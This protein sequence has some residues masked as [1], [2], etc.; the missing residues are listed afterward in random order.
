MREKREAAIFGHRP[1]LEDGRPPM[2]W[3]ADMR[4]RTRAQ[5]QWAVKLIKNNREMIIRDKVANPFNNASGYQ[6][7]NNINK[8]KTCNSNV[9][10]I[11]YGKSG[12]DACNVFKNKYENVHNRATRD[13]ELGGIVPGTHTRI[14]RECKSR[15][16]SPDHLN[17]VTVKHII[18]TI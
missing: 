10:E 7:W 3:L 11:I 1:R 18:D 2:G 4:R 12:I 15:E 17:S 5:Y 8:L 14:C 16:N 6:F 13:V 9:N